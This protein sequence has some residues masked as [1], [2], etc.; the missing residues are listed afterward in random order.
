MLSNKFKSLSPYS[1]KPKE[2]L[3]PPLEIKLPN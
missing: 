1:L 3:K 2:A